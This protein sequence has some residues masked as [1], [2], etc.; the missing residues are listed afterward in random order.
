MG[1]L[2]LV[3]ILAGAAYGVGM[4][5]SR[6]PEKLRP[7]V[8]FVAALL[9]YPWLLAALSGRS[10]QEVV[11]GA[12][13][14]LSLVWYLQ[15][16]FVGAAA[17]ILI[18][19]GFGVV[20]AWRNGP[21]W[22]RQLGIGLMLCPL[23][24]LLLQPLGIDDRAPGFRVRVTRK[25]P[26]FGPPSERENQPFVA[27]PEPD[28]VSCSGL[29]SPER[30][31]RS[32]RRDYR[33]KTFRKHALDVLER[34]FPAGAWVARSLSDP[35]QF[36]FWFGTSTA[37]FDQMLARLSGAVHESVHILG[38]QHFALRKRIYPLEP[39]TLQQVPHLRLFDRSRILAQLP[40]KLKF[41]SYNKTYLQGK[42]GQQGLD[43][44][45]D[46]FNAYTWSLLVDLATM[47]QTPH[48]VSRSSRD[49]LLMF[50]LYLQI[51]LSIARTQEAASYAKL[52]KSAEL[53]RFIVL[54]WDRAR[55]VLRL[56]GR[57]RRIGHYDLA[58]RGYVFGKTRLREVERLRTPAR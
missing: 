1:S 13:S 12:F 53:R 31:L 16:A 4:L 56:S 21:G 34:R 11:A 19:G 29:V 14:P 23:V 52:V 18:G 7:V 27:D 38:S 48:N 26:G 5:W 35:K 30:D 43:S 41:L 58:L 9:L 40:A 46:E 33:P 22:R 3:L 42:S 55:C 39:R 47:D 20:A 2:S 15:P 10:A 28:R 51:Y 17:L 32:I 57:D 44:L 24:A 54:L 37:S 45:L 36:D 49:G 8:G 25:S 50:M 6:S